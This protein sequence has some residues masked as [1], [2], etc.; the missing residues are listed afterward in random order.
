MVPDSS[1][2]NPHYFCSEE[3]VIDYLNGE[4]PSE[5]LTEDKERSLKDG[6]SDEP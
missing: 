4:C 5:D 6:D 2:P 1:D 3:C